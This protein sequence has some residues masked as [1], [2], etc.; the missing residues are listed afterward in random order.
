[1]AL[2]AD[3]ELGG[4]DQTFNLLMG[5]FLQEQYGQE[6]QVI[7]TVPLLVGLDGVQKMSKSLGN[8]I[9]ISEPADDAFGK[10]MS[11][12]DL[13]MW[14]YFT[15]LLGVSAIELSALQEKVAYGT[16]HP[17]ALKK[18][19]AYDIIAKFWSK[20][21]LTPHEQNLKRYSRKKITLKLK[22]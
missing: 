19:M 2:H 18:Q 17:M 11:I 22:K 1:M 15:L 12:S 6:P 21:K 8:A 10:L 16:T 13:T 4:T 9:G 20:K 3:V 14:P 5:R 7:L